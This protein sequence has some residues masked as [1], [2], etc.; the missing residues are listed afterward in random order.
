M[1]KISVYRI[2][3]PL[4]FS[5][6]SALL[7]S[8]CGGS[9]GDD[10]GGGNNNGGGST[11]SSAKDAWV[12]GV[13]K[14]SDE[15][16]N[17]CASPR[18]GVSRITGIRFPD[19]KGTSQQEKNFLRSW[20]YETYLWFEDLPDLNP[21]NSDTP[22]AYFNRLVSNKRTAS[23]AYKDN[24]HFYEPT[25]DEEAWSAGI[26]Y[27]YGLNLKIN[28]D[29]PR[30][31]TVAYSDT[32]SPAANN[33]IKRGAKI[34][35]VDGLPVATMN[36][37]TL[38]D[39]LYPTQINAIHEFEIQDL[40]ASETRKVVLES[41]SLDT[42]SVTVA[43]AIDHDGSKVGYVQFNTFIP[44]AQDKWVAAV[45]QLN[46]AGVTD[47]VVDMRYNGG[48]YIAVASQVAYM[49]AGTQTAGKVFYQDVANSK[50][51]KEDPWE[52][53][54]IGL[55]GAYAY[56]PLPT[57]NLSRVYVL[58]TSGTCSASRWTAS[59][60]KAARPSTSRW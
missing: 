52:F 4:I 26:T 10:L 47:L 43:K 37:N 16:A 42:D 22:Q 33:S 40:G 50:M 58:A 7:L 14:P 2:A 15:Y 44:D 8:A 29:I 12:A 30:T 5:I 56:S 3:S 1:H 19:K 28:W 11:S 60:S 35:A 49:I 46:Q 32:A 20:S 39:A 59:S 13:Y 34:I 57:L 55:Y 45:N 48:G 23:G 17:Y 53:F 36:Q 38:I 24:F 27:G 54:D 51:P 9:A 6:A 31:I 21:N 25:E 18:S 41:A